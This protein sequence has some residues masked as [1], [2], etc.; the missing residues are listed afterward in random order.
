MAALARGFAGANDLI[1]RG[2]GKGQVVVSL[3]RYLAGDETD[4]A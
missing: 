4:P 3:D 2:S 1:A